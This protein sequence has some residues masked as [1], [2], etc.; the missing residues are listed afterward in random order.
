MA[1][2][3]SVL[4]V[5]VSILLI[6]LVLLQAGKGA[7][8]G[9]S[10]GSGSS[11]ALFG[12]SGPA[13]FLTK[14]TTLCAVIFMFTSLYLTYVSSRIDDSIMTSVPEMQNTPEASQ[15]PVETTSGAMPVGGTEKK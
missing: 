9:A 6:V 3:V 15:K 13:T 8:M 11:Q 14:L 4:H 12:S 1:S 10:F 7:S 5:L 2:T